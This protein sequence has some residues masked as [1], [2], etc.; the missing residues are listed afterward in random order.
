MKL[1]LL[2]SRGGRCQCCRMNLVALHYRRAAARSGHVLCE[3]IVGRL[4][5]LVVIDGRMLLGVLL[6]DG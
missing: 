4:L 1:L 6:V 5:L 3:D 2:V